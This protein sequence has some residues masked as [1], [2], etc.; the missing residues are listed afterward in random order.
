MKAKFCVIAV[1]LAIVT[2]FFSCATNRGITE[3]TM[4]VTAEGTTEG[5]VLHFSNIPENTRALMV[6]IFDITADGQPTEDP[7]AEKSTLFYIHEERLAEL[8][9]SGTLLC[10]FV[11]NGHEYTVFI[12]DYTTKYEIELTNVIAGGGIYLT[13]NPTL[14][15]T[16]NN[17]TVTLSEMPTFSE[18]VSIS[19][20]GL[21]EFLNF[22]IIDDNLYGGGMGG[23]NELTYPARQ[24][25]SDTQEHFGF[26]GDFPV[27]AAVRC[28]LV[29][30]ND[31]W[32]VAVA[33]A[34]GTAIMSF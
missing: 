14:N 6:R 4:S 25:L 31:E 19:P 29:Y 26:T 24:V 27:N 18:E 22:V 8:K 13:N 5:I 10:P 3:N 9:R 20:R 2:V 15:F 28:L 16:D 11:R 34:E 1:I 23:W 32:A 33:K 30:D 12:Y 7:E 21:L 17:M